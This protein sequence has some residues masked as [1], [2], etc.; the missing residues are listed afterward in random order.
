MLVGTYYV[1]FEYQ[2]DNPWTFCCRLKVNHV[3]SYAFLRGLN[4]WSTLFLYP[5]S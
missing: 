3:I 5:S 1:K 4:M 2:W